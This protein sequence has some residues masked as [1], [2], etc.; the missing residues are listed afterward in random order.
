MDGMRQREK[1]CIFRVIMYDRHK[2]SKTEPMPQFILI[3]HWKLSHSE[4]LF[5]CAMYFHL[6]EEKSD[7]FVS[8]RNVYNFIFVDVDVDASRYYHVDLHIFFILLVWLWFF[9]PKYKLYDWM[10]Q[11]TWILCEWSKLQNNFFFFKDV[12]PILG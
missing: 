10:S 3:E 6:K 11:S 5:V 12:N 4:L 9:F 7:I 8:N 1:I 2:L